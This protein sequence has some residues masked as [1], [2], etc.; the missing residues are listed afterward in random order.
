M[1]CAQLMMAADPQ[2]HSGCCHPISPPISLPNGTPSTGIFFSPSP[3]V[4]QHGQYLP[5]PHQL[6]VCHCLAPAATGLAAVLLA[7]T[8]TVQNVQFPQSLHLLLPPPATSSLFQPRGNQIGICHENEERFFLSCATS[9]P[10]FCMYSPRTGSALPAQP[11]STARQVGKRKECLHVAIPSNWQLT[12]PLALTALG[13][14]E[15]QCKHQLIK[16]QQPGGGCGFPDHRRHR[17]ARE[18]CLGASPP[19]DQRGAAPTLALTVMPRNTLCHRC[20]RQ[21]RTS[22]LPTR[23]HPLGG[24]I[25]LHWCPGSIL[26]VLQSLLG[27]IPQHMAGCLGLA[28]W[29]GKMLWD[30]RMDAG[31][32]N[33][34]WRAAPWAPTDDYHGVGG[35]TRLDTSA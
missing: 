2:L 27:S 19:W 34:L 8:I 5:P 13:G 17:Q 24:F 16:Q 4:E 3:C 29:R 9:C 33:S 6:A 14:S 11:G 18:G 21:T 23:T 15:V 30:P 35:N 26:C 32:T 12:Q 1:P 7:A 10:Y 22:V 31:D 25:H 28:V 20:S